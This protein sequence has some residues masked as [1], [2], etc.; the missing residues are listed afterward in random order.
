MSIAII[1]GGIIGTSIAYHL[2]HHGEKVT[3]IDDQRS[4]RA[5]DAGAGIV[6][7]WVTKRNKKTP[8]YELSTRGATYYETLQ[9]QLEAE[10]FGN[11]GY[12]KVG[13]LAISTDDHY[14]SQLE[15]ELSDEKKRNPSIGTLERL[16]KE[17]TKE[18]FPPLHEQYESVFVG[19]GARVDGR[20]LQ[21]AM[22]QSAQNLGVRWVNGTAN[23]LNAKGEDPKL[24]VNGEVYTPRKVIVASGAWLEELQ[25]PVRPKHKIRS[26]RGQ[27]VHLKAHGEETSDWP[28]IQP[29]SSYYI[30]S[31]EESRIVVGATREDGK[32]LTDQ[33]TAGG[34]HEVLSVTSELIPG[35]DQYEW[36]ET[37]VGFRPISAEN[38]PVLGPLDEA[39]TFY[40]ANGF[41]ATGLTMGPYAGKLLADL[42]HTDQAEMDI[43]AFYPD[44]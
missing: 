25:L 31:F 23:V 16:S 33:V 13:T 19:G 20:K 26:Q 9:K 41:G 2:A 35:S 38:K 11:T 5:T 17:R 36:L 6:C 34:L 1:G 8:G 39:R 7:P 43:R 22:Q 30:L 32:G 42:V 27:I 40:V 37:R 44:I 29:E 12:K 10:G 24:E 28:I 4:G 21:L 18:K 15:E 3:V 14:L